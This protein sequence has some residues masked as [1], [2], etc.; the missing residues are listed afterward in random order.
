MMGIFALRLI[1]RWIHG[2]IKVTRFA[3]D[4]HVTFNQSITQSIN[5]S[6][7]LKTARSKPRAGPHD[8][9]PFVYIRFAN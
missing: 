3:V 7:Q 8:T 6:P 9:N 4:G 1:I 2:T 5:Q